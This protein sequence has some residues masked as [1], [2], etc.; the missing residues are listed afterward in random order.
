MNGLKWQTLSDTP[1]VRR[2]AYGCE[3]VICKNGNSG[4]KLSTNRKYSKNEN[5]SKCGVYCQLQKK[6]LGC[7]KLQGLNE[8]RLGVMY[9][10]TL[11]CRE[12]SC[13]G[14]LVLD[15]VLLSC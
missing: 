4:N 11:P 5:Y 15:K 3:T 9:Y 2:L 14:L 8:K 13:T 10:K 1:H 12:K 7:D 6:Y